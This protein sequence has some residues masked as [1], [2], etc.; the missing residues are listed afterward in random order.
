SDKISASW[1]EARL[2]QALVDIEE[3]FKHY[4]LSDALMT[5]YKLVWD[6]F[7]AWY[8]ELVKP[9]YGSPISAETLETVK[10]FFQ[11]ILTLVH[12][13]MPFLTEELWHD[14]LFGVK[15]EK[16]C[17]IVASYPTAEEFDE[18]LIKDFAIAQQIISEV[19]N[20]RNSKGIS[21]KVALPLAINQQ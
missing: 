12:P 14:E 9:A 15:D 2:N 11:R 17:I 1:F 13:F 16:D 6:D 20:I 5:T 7:C 4:R 8:L 18:Q 3:N 10:S 21:P 19:R